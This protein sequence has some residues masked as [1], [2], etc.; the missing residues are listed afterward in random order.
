MDQQVETT[1]A[2]SNQ[3]SAQ[4]AAAPASATPARPKTLR[5]FLILAGVLGTLAIIGVIYWLHARNFAT[6]TDAEIDGSV[7]Q[8]APRVAGQ[9]QQ[10]F[11][12]DN[13]HVTKGQILVQLDQSG[14]IVA[15]DKAKASQAEAAA[16]LA[17]AQA[18]LALQSANLAQSQA[19]VTVAQASLAQTTSNFDRYRAVNPRAITR[20]QLDDAQA[21]LRT[22]KAKFDASKAGADGARA[23]VQAAQAQVTAAEAS[24]QAAEVGVQNAQLQLSYTTITAPAAGHVAEKTVETGNVVAA[25]SALMAVVSD[26]VWVTANY[27]ETSLPGIHVGQNVRVYVDAAP[28][29]GFHAVVQS[30]Q[31]GTGSIF[32]LLPAENATGNYVKVVQRV[33]VKITFDDNRIDQYKLAPGMS[34]EPYIRIK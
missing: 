34:A 30:I 19:N 4:T 2:P 21:A 23:S 1:A 10:I 17:Q 14:E 3:A 27:K 22:A 26:H 20:Q 16:S 5:P 6:T 33:P 15:L 25:G 29:I 7:H 8:I 13:E 32:S 11:V 12:H 31:H 9:V 28:G 24:L 18:Q